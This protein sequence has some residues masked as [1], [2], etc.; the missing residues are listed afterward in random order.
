MT[1]SHWHSRP[2][3]RWR[4]QKS[5]TG[6]AWDVIRNFDYAAILGLLEGRPDWAGG[7]AHF[8]W[9]ARSAAIA[10]L[11]RMANG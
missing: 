1:L 3:G 10:A 6:Y 11:K 2:G 4:V 5:G 9:Q 7:R 8:A